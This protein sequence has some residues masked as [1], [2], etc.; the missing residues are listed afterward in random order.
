MQW[1][2]IIW[3]LLHKSVWQPSN[4]R[5]F[6]KVEATTMPDITMCHG[7]GCFL[8]ETC[9]RYKAKPTKE[10]QAYFTT[11]PIETETIDGSQSCA[12]YIVDEAADL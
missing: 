8:Q 1:D 6:S 11:P 3:L 10:R 9:Y 2:T 4:K 7:E 12:Y 5:V